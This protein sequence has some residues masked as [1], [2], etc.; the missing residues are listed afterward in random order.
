VSERASQPA[1]SDRQWFFLAAGAV[2][3]LDFLSKRWAENHLPI[4]MLRTGWGP[5]RWRLVHNTGAAFG[6]FAHGNNALLAGLA[7]VAALLLLVYVLSRPQRLAMAAGLGM[8]L[9]GTL[10]NLA[11][12]LMQGTVTDFLVVPFWPAIF[13][14]ADVGI[15]AGALLA[16]IALLWPRRQFSVGGP[17]PG[18]TVR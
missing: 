13:N 10:G 6:L 1:R 18:R 5:L 7:V 9:G 14:V 11:D 2:L 8:V 15:R 12:R 16:I 3:A 4:N 17:H